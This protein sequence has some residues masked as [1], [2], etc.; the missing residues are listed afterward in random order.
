[1]SQPDPALSQ[2]FGWI[3]L[4]STA[5]ASPAEWSRSLMK[6]GYNTQAVMLDL[7]CKAHGL[8]TGGLFVAVES[9]PYH[10]VSVYTVGEETLRRSRHLLLG[11]IQGIGK[12]RKEGVWPGYYP[13]IQTIDAPDFWFKQ[14]VDS[15]DE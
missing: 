1:M 2:H 9:E 10:G 15:L 6:F 14:F 12:C 7:A 13:R 3:D 11:W 4:K 8:P 5:N